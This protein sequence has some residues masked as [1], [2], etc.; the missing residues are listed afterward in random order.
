MI[1]SQSQ[2]SENSY[3]HKLEK[4]NTT[5]PVHVQYIVATAC[6]RQ[7]PPYYS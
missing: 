5:E 3:N 1:Q 6:V 4:V 7:P 2:I